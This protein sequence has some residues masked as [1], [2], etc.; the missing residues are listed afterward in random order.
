VENIL[1]CLELIIFIV[2]LIDF[3]L[4]D[5]TFHVECSCFMLE[6]R[7]FQQEWKIFL[8]EEEILNVE[9]A[10]E[11]EKLEARKM[12]VNHT[13]SHRSDACCVRWLFDF[14]GFLSLNSK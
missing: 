12:L 9:S 3:N 11:Q 1:F 14:H 7:F 4:E 2:E 8:Q 6:G 13:D 5:D 10:W